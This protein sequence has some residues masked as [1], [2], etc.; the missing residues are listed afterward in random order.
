MR[1]ARDPHVFPELMVENFL[2]HKVREIFVS[3]WTNADVYVDISDS[4][5][6]KLKSLQEHA[7]QTAANWE[8]VAPRVRER[9]RAMA[10]ANNLPF[11]YTEAYKY[12]RL[13]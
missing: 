13:D 12:F 3:S 4:F 8:E 9:S 10:K 6:T 2:P 11:E 5:E 1:S 7:S